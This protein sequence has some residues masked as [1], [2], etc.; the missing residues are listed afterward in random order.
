[1]TSTTKGAV[2][3]NMTFRFMILNSEKE[4]EEKVEFSVILVSTPNYRQRGVVLKHVVLFSMTSRIKV[5]TV[6]AL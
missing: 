5:T 1:M 3:D 2:L 4:V 6:C